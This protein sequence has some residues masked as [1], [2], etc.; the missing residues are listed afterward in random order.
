[1]A[2]VAP[3]SIH[4]QLTD[5]EMEA[6]LKIKA[7]AERKQKESKVLAEV[8][9]GIIAEIFNF[10]G[11]QNYQIR[12]IIASRVNTI[13]ERDAVKSGR[14]CLDFFTDKCEG[15]CKRMHRDVMSFIKND[16]IEKTK[17]FLKAQEMAKKPLCIN[18]IRYA[19]CDQIDCKRHHVQKIHDPIYFDFDQKTMII[20]CKTVVVKP[21]AILP[22]KEDLGG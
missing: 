18:F 14:L 19:K 6:N 16:E 9:G 8:R 1:M 17:S 5:A 3:L 7:T 11:L 13:K 20:L 4:T 10:K 22:I 2:A 15:N 21:I 12:R